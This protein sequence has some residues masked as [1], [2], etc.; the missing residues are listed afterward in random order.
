MNRKLP[1]NPASMLL[2]GLIAGAAS[3][4]FDIYFNVLGRIFSE[5]TV[6]ILI[7]TLIAIYSP[8]GKK[9]CLIFFRSV[10]VCLLRIMQRQL[11]QT[12]YLPGAI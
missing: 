12:G 1:L 3:R 8:T 2:C 6:W 10:W 9:Q 11:S 4:L 5:M 7:S